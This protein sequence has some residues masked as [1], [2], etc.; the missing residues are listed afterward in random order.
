MS[1]NESIS[2]NINAINKEDLRHV[3]ARTMRHF[4]NNG[5]LLWFNVIKLFLKILV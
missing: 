3:R 4:L 2:K 5:Y 1:K